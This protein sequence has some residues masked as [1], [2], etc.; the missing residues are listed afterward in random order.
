MPPAQSLDRSP[1][2]LHQELPAN[3]AVMVRNGA[4]ITDS[5]I[6]GSCS[7]ASISGMVID[8][9]DRCDYPLRHFNLDISMQ[10]CA[11]IKYHSPCTRYMALVSKQW[12]SYQ[13]S[14][15][16]DYA[17]A[18][19]AGNV[20]PATDLKGNRLLAIPACIMARAVMHVGIAN[21]RWQ[22]KRSWHSWR[23]HKKKFYISGK[24]PMPI[25]TF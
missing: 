2:K 24:R 3:H 7:V 22:G 9:T 6:V 1:H 13:I 10:N 11:T 17:C 20:F 14:K 8:T 5:A 16:A 12:A 23:M 19:N 15:M 21:L 18:G 25:Y 4:E